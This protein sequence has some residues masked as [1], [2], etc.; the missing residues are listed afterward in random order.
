MGELRTNV[1]E[2]FNFITAKIE[3]LLGFMEFAMEEVKR[4][5]GQ[6]VLDGIVT[7]IVDFLTKFKTNSQ[8]FVV[9]VF[10][11]VFGE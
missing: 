6:A 5:S 7:Q 2:T 3:V 4:M 8:D 10:Q 11:E 1:T 9:F